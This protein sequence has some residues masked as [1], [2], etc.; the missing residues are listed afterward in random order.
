MILTVSQLSTK[1]CMRV[2]EVFSK[3]ARSEKCLKNFFPRVQKSKTANIAA[4]FSSNADSEEWNIGQISLI[5]KLSFDYK[6]TK[7]RQHSKNYTLEE[8]MSNFEI[9]CLDEPI[10]MK[11][12]CRHRFRITSNV[13]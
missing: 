4:S 1:K 5:S 13:L 7:I 10:L 6:F 8:S 3:R 11:P 9:I 2:S 12:K